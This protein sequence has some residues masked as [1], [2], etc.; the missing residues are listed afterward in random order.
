LLLALKGSRD[1]EK[2]RATEELN[3]IDTVTVSNSIYI[4]K[5]NIDRELGKKIKG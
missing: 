2:R 4:Y 5:L 1:A 3:T